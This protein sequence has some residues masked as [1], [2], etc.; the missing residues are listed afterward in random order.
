MG[1]GSLGMDY[2]MRMLNLDFETYT[3]DHSPAGPA[4]KRIL[5]AALQAVDPAAAVTHHLRKV[6]DELIA[7]GGAQAVKLKLADYANIYLVGAGKAGAPMALAITHLLGERLT[8][9]VVVVKDGHAAL[10]AAETRPL[11]WSRLEMVEA[12][13]PVPD[14]RGVQATHRVLELLKTTSER[15]LVLCLISGG[16]SALLTQPAPGLSLPDLQELTHQLLA[17]GAS[18][19]EI[20][21]LR[22]HLDTIKGGGLARA[23]APARVLTLILSDVVGDPLDVIASG[24]TVPD[25]STYS[26]AWQVL[27]RYDLVQKVPP[28]IREHLEAGRQAKIPETAKPGDPIFRQVDNLVVGSNLLAAQAA[29]R[30][31]RLEGFQTLLLTTY[32]QGEARQAGRLLAAL[33]RQV[34]ASA[35]PLPPP[36]C[37]IVGGETTV[38]LQGAGLGGRNQELVLGAVQEISRLPQTLLA[39][40]AT[41]GGDGPTDAA[42][43]VA[44]GE[45]LQRAAELGLQPAEFLARNDAYHFFEKLG[46]L[47]KTGPTQ[48][49]VN[50]LAIL[51]MST[52][53][54]T[55]E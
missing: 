26:E 16:G 19:D 3:L 14:A 1:P 24:P 33:A 20:N 51:V 36:V 27:E 9:G 5:R 46:D 11:G 52:P 50:D 34:T 49:N 48:T 21:S 4:V 35:D 29:Q 38:T 7:E 53:G 30:Q 39:S 15:D 18:I 45:T 6:G 12:G 37:L 8:A 25:T 47:L 10:R 2:N 54:Q 31:A 43:A 42:G 55:P 28:A 44:S 23:A 17:C 41:D 13:H 40:L 32:L 22:K